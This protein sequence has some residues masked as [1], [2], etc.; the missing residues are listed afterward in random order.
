[1]KIKITNADKVL[2]GEKIKKHEHE[3][4]LNSTNLSINKTKILHFGIF[5]LGKF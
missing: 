2:L 4:A 1:M 5:R 3:Q